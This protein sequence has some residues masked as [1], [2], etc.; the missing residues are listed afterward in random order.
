MSANI[1]IA[2]DVKL[3]QHLKEAGVAGLNASVLSEKTGVDVALLQRLAEKNYQH[4]ISFCYDA[5]RPSFNGFPEFFKKTHYQSPSLGSLEGLFQDAHKT[6]LPFFEWR[7]HHIS[8][9]LTRL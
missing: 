7:R 9:T 4:S 8:S 5:A 1:R 6:R 3:F 2:V